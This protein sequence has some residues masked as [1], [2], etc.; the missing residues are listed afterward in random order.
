MFEELEHV[1]G[2][3]D[4]LMVRVP[5][6]DTLFYPKLMQGGFMVRTMTGFSFPA[7]SE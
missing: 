1:C 2:K 3:G 7:G 5:A 6:L 4:F